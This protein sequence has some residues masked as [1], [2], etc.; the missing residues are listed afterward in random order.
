MFFFLCLKDEIDFTFFLGQPKYFIKY[1]DGPILD[2]SIHDNCFVASNCVIKDNDIYKMYYLSCDKWIYEKGN[3]KHF[4]NIKYAESKNAIHW[5][6]AGHIAIDYKN[7]DEYAISVPR[8]V[9]ENSIYNNYH[10]AL[11]APLRAL[12]MGP[13]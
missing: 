6:R 10:T 9:F 2:R 11:R 7:K 8:V 12:N 4:Y 5:D 1:S 13:L 3:L